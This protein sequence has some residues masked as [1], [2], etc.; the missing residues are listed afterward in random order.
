MPRDNKIDVLSL[1]DLYCRKVFKFIYVMTQ[2]YHTAEDLAHDTFIKISKSS[3]QLKNKEKIESWIFQIAHNT[4]M[5]YIRKKKLKLDYFVPILL[6]K[7]SSF[8]IENQL[9]IDENFRELYEILSTLKPAYREV[10]IFRKIEGYSTKE[11]S[12]ILNWSESKV[13][14]T[15]SRAMTALQQELSDVGFIFQHTL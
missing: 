11:T 7:E 3:H 5:D 10:I 1:Y 15:L 2:D 4:T 9:I 8:S 14:S 13:K 12:I 6:E